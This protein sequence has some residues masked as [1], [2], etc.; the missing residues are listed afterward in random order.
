ML[1]WSTLK[2]SFF[3]IEPK[4]GYKIIEVLVSIHGRLDKLCRYIDGV[5]FAVSKEAD[6]DAK[7]SEI[8]KPIMPSVVL[9]LMPRF[10]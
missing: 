7:T 3:T 8:K 10:F 4:T 9:K 1:S 5:P 2:K 6:E